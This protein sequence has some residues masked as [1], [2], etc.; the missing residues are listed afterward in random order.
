MTT[1]DAL[2]GSLYEYYGAMEDE[3]AAHLVR[4]E[5]AIA[6]QSLDAVT[7]GLVRQAIHVARMLGRTEH[8]GF[9]VSSGALAKPQ[10]R[11]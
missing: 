1:A 8:E 3:Y 2:L 11:T 7:A 10:D 6:A 4:L 5:A 9:L